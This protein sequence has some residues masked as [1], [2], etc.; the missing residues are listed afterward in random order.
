MRSR[1]TYPNHRSSKLRSSFKR[2]A[3]PQPLP[4]R[5][6]FFTKMERDNGYHSVEIRN[7]TALAVSHSLTEPAELLL[8]PLLAVIGYIAALAVLSYMIFALLLEKFIRRSR[9]LLHTITKRRS[10]GTNVAGLTSTRAHESSNDVES[11]TWMCTHLLHRGSNGQ[12]E[13]S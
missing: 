11:N 4:E 1:K 2:S 6:G 3:E 12:K 9:R 7:D 5:A 13:K 10:I 8:S